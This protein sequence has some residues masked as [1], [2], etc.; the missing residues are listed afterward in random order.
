MGNLS[1][2]N[3]CV[4]WPTVGYS[5]TGFPPTWK[6]RKVREMKSA[7][8]GKVVENGKIFQKVREIAAKMKRLCNEE[9]GQN[10]QI[11]VKGS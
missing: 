9:E 6:V 8:S 10:T 5:R 1:D 11:S 7:W 3:P 4:G 2:V